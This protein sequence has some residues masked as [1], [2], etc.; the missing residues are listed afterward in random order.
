M[1][2]QDLIDVIQAAWINVPSRSEE[3]RTLETLLNALRKA[4]QKD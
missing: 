1:E 3:E 2:L 4:Q